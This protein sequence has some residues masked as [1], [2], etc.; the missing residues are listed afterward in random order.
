MRG[1]RDPI[2]SIGN[3]PAKF[4]I[5]YK[6]ILDFAL[7]PSP[8]G[9]SEITPLRSVPIFHEC[10]SKKFYFPTLF[11]LT[12]LNPKEEK[13]NFEKDSLKM[14]LSGYRLKFA[15]LIGPW[16]FNHSDKKK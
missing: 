9:A 11:C 6:Y 5:I 12:H 16:T 2:S 14:R 3:I 13:T 4:Y 10:Y 7:P 8:Q 15:E 1:E